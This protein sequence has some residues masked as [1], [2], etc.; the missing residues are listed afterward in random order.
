MQEKDGVS[1]IPTVDSILAVKNTVGT[2]NIEDWLK[3]HTFTE[4]GHGSGDAIIELKSYGFA[5]KRVL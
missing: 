2:I 5:L 4:I 1:V 3:K